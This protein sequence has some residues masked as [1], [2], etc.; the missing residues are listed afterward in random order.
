M[1]AVI[2]AGGKGT[3]LRSV[4]EELPKPMV[5]VLGKPV[6][7]YQLDNLRQCGITDII[8]VVGYR[9]SYIRDHFGDGS[10]F[11]V[12]ISYINEDEPLGTAGALYFLKEILDE[13]FLLLMGDLMLS[14]DFIRFMDFHKKEGGEAT[15][16]VHPNSHPYD[17]DIIIMDT[18]GRLSEY[19][20]DRCKRGGRP[21]HASGSARVRGVIGKSSERPEVYHN[22][23]NAGIYALS[24]KILEMIKEPKKLDLDRDII[25]PLIEKGRI[26]AYRSS[27]YVKDMGTPERYETVA[28]DIGSG[29]VRSRNLKNRQKCIFLDRDG[30]LN[31][32]I[33]LLR[34]PEE[35][36]LIPG[37]AEAIRLIN[38]SEYLAIVI[39]NQP[40]IA[41]G[42]VSFEELDLINARLETELG[43]KGAYLDDLFF[44]PHHPDS[45]FEGE[46]KELKFD[47]CCRKPETGMLMAAAEKYNIDLSASYMIGDMT[48]DICCGQRAGTHTVLLGTGKAGK[49][50][51]YECRPDLKSADILEAVKSIMDRTQDL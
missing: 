18:A 27:E 25:R 14:V 34:K 7:E 6:L 40:V 43:S 19:T 39:T 47:C 26:A 49:D 20:E 9:S 11:S 30:T 17:S 5:P 12:N 36:E 2:M 35:L 16:F 28:R 32:Y 42:E 3:R 8:M 21:P 33:G 4:S 38:E 29:L 37:A 51:H 22:I 31:R 23:V 24:P 46:I 15:L 1:K 45:G 13:D 50:V 10:R 44:C 41:R 48:M